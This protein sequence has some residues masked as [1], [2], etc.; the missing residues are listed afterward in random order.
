MARPPGLILASA[1]LLTW[2][3]RG[4]LEQKKRAGMRRRSSSRAVAGFSKE[5]AFFRKSADG[6]MY[7]IDA[8]AAC[9]MGNPRR[10]LWGL[11]GPRNRRRPQG[12]IPGGP[13]GHP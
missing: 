2:W 8:R 13:V 3:R 5:M 10:R 9:V 6:T 12:G 4:L 7:R 11:H 1:G